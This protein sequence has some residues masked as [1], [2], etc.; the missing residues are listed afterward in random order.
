MPLFPSPNIVFGDFTVTED[1]IVNTIL[2]TSKVGGDKLCKF[3]SRAWFD[4][5]TLGVNVG[6]VSIGLVDGGD[7]WNSWGVADLII[8]SDGGGGANHNL[9]TYEIMSQTALGL[10]GAIIDSYYCPIDGLIIDDRYP[11]VDFS[12]ASVHELRQFTAGP[13]F[14]GGK[15]L[16][17]LFAN[18]TQIQ[19]GVFGSAA[20]SR[21]SLTTF[22][23]NFK[24]VEWSGLGEIS[25]LGF[26]GVPVVARQSHTSLT[27]GT[28]GGTANTLTTFTGAVYATDAPIIKG[29]IHQLGI[30]VNAI[31]TVLTNLGLVS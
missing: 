11:D 30:A 5:N 13:T 17:A 29:D 8:G 24:I 1:F 3:T 4:V 15:G 28:T 31:W 12:T 25:Q 23:G 26:Y 27:D 22:P 16:N 2:E 18:T 7:P 6:G 20:L 14:T 9:V 19:T 21:R 10:Q